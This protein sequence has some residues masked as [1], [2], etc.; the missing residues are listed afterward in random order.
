MIWPPQSTCLVKAALTLIAVQRN[1]GRGTCVPP[2]MADKHAHPTTDPLHQNDDRLAH[3]PQPKFAAAW[4]ALVGEP[5]ALM[6]ES[7]SEMIRLL[8][9]SV[10]V[11]QPA[12]RNAIGG[13]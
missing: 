8:V 12:E 3:V 2:P 9:G 7:R 1:L 6:L 11:A 4:T 10:P 5:P 13:G